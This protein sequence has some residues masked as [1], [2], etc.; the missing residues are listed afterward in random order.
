MREYSEPEAHFLD[1]C[2]QGVYLALSRIHRIRTREIDRDDPRASVVLYAGSHVAVLSLS[3][4]ILSEVSATPFT[5]A[6]PAAQR[7][8]LMNLFAESHLGYEEGAPVTGVRCDWVSEVKGGF[9]RPSGWEVSL[10]TRESS[11]WFFPQEGWGFGGNESPE[12]KTYERLLFP[13][14]WRPPR[15]SLPAYRQVQEGT[16]QD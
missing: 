15:W 8:W 10:V 5:P 1:A 2:F 9:D 16:G 4:A 7:E 6:D 3:R 13:H 14:S 11:H 12:A